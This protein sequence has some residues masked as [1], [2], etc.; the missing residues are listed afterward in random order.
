MRNT[1]IFGLK[2]AVLGAQTYFPSIFITSHFEKSEW[3]TRLRTQYCCTVSGKP[4]NSSCAGRIARSRRTTRAAWYSRNVYLLQ[5]RANPRHTVEK[6]V[7][8]L[9]I[10]YPVHN[11][12]EGLFGDFKLSKGDNV[13]SLP[14][15]VG[16]SAARSNHGGVGVY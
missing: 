7:P 16:A 6:T 8:P 9:V 5:L 2:H 4:R 15:K 12:H 14:P 11:R 1:R 13:E 3:I 10:I